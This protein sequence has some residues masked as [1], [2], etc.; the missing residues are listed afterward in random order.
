MNEDEIIELVELR[1]HELNKLMSGVEVE[2][3][4]RWLRQ[5]HQ[6]NLDVLNLLRRGQPIRF[7]RDNI[8]GELI[9]F[10]ELPR[11]VC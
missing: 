1:I 7:Y 5:M 11:F 9:P 6:L 4:L 2:R 3:E 10:L 8:G